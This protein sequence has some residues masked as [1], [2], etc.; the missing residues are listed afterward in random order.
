MGHLK[1]D[2]CISTDLARQVAER[3]YVL[4]LNG[5]FNAAHVAIDSA[6]LTKQDVKNSKL[7]DTP[8]ALLDLDDKIIN[9]FEKMGY[10]HVRDLVGV[11]DEHLL[12]TVPM[13]GEK[14]IQLMRD[15]LLSEMTRRRQQ[16]SSEE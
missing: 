12:K 11:T 15:A 3:V 7:S 16:D 13:C 6:Q 14:S 8:L 4:L 2:Y 10:T 1:N 5:H 9:L